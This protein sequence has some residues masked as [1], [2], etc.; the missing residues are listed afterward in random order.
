VA[1]DYGGGV[2][3]PCPALAFSVTLILSQDVSDTERDAVVADLIALLDRH[4]LSAA[5]R[6]RRT[7]LV[8]RREGSQTTDAD[9]AIVRAWA[10]RWAD[11]LGVDVGDLRDLALT[12]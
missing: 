9:R 11:R 12:D 4:G 2:S 3:A 1:R 7:E 8:V 6:G 5:H 10:D